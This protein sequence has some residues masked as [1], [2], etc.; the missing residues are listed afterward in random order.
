MFARMGL[1][2]RLNLI[3]ISVNLT[4]LVLVALLAN[5]S[6]SSELRFQ[7]VNRF[8]QKSENAFTTV[9]TEL[10]NF[11]TFATTLA[12]G[13]G[14]FGDMSVAS[15]VNTFVVNAYQEELN[16]NAALVYNVSVVR[17]NGSIIFSN[18]DRT[19]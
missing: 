12:E 5:S 6:I 7:A 13:I 16:A 3:I 18:S 8:N 2:N 17:P 1:G 11:H 9:D 14:N 10:N 15:E 4:I 19:V